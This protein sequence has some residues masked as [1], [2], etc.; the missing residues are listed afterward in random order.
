MNHACR[1]QGLGPRTACPSVC[2]SISLPLCRTG[3]LGILVRGVYPCPP[4][5]TDRGP[6]VAD[7]SSVKRA[8][9]EGGPH[10][11]RRALRKR[12]AGRLAPVDPGLLSLTTAPCGDQAV[13]SSAPRD[14]RARG[15]AAEGWK[16]V[17][18]GSLPCGLDQPRGRPSVFFFGFW[19]LTACFSRLCQHGAA[20]EE[21]ACL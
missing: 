2:L 7:V 8:P 17:S 18:Q 10:L 6:T 20:R 11:Q 13:G 12:T 19:V 14:R 21:G 3:G 5:A 16:L 4:S 1:A 9:P 15:G